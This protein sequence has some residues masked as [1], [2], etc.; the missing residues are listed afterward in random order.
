VLVTLVQYSLRFSLFSDHQQTKPDK[1]KHKRQAALTCPTILQPV[2]QGYAV[3]D[4]AP[5]LL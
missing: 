1:S 5:V 4:Y 3:I 2:L